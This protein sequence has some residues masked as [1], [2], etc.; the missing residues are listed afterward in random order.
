MRAVV[1]LVA[2]RVC[3][4]PARSRPLCARAG[5]DS[6][7]PDGTPKKF[8][9]R[10]AWKNWIDWDSPY[11]EPTDENNRARHFF[12]HVDSRGRLWREE[13]DR[14]GERF[15]QMRDTRV[16]DFFFGHVQRNETGLHGAEYPFV[17][18]RMH[19]HYFTRCADAPVVFND[20]RDGEL[21]HV[22][23]DGEL[24]RSV[25]TRFDASALQLTPEGKLFHPVTTRATDA[26]GAPRREE[27]MGLIESTTAQ[28]L[29][30]CCEEEAPSNGG[31]GGG[32]LLRWRGEVHRLR[33]G[34]S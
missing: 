2:R 20:L 24:A 12:W 3:L 27:L 33:T 14:P 15:G 31:N 1:P 7:W 16:L 10:E 29:L 23:P 8:R 18:F 22:C 6:H 13:L 25:T 28:Q 4:R 34:P 11:R 5:D 32:M 21:R 9:G 26:D 30:E 19:E 17:S